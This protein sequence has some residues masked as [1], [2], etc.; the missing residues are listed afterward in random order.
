MKKAKVSIIIPVYNS[1]EI[2]DELNQR[3]LKTFENINLSESFE[4][5]M[6]NDFSKDKSWE[7]IEHLSSKYNY[8]KGIKLS[9]NF[10][11]HNAIMAGLN[12]CNGE[13]VITIDDDLQH[14]PEFFPEIIKKLDNSD[15]CYTNYRNR[16][17]NSW[18]K[19]ISI[20]NNIVSSFLLN[21]PLN[22]YMSSFRGLKRNIV[23]EIIK[24]KKPNVYIDGIIIGATKNIGMITVDHDERKSGKSN[25]DLRK[26]FILW[27][28]MIIDLKFYP[29][30][31]S[32]V[33]GLILKFFVILFRNKENKPQYKISEYTP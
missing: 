4:V 22:I 2:L 3:I 14:P 16:K 12:N 24:F 6:I 17:H 28:N 25:Y 10:G 23:L 27:S 13:Y 30:R 1:F 20:I 15:V 11:Q 29:I 31:F 9:E 26:L 33:F 18:K 21:K 8:I 7:K 5:I 32:S 19:T